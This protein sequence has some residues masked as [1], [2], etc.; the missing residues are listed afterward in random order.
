MLT[1]N[2]R[3]RNL[4]TALVLISVVAVFFVGVVVRRWLYGG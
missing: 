4:R 3:R 1:D 2:D